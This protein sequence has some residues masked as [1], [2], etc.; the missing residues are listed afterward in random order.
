MGLLRIKFRNNPAKLRL[1]S[2]LQ[3]NANSIQGK[4][5][6]TL[7]FESAWE[8]GDAAYMLEDGTTLAQ[9]KTLRELCGTSQE[10]VTDEGAEETEASGQ[11]K[12]K[13]EHQGACARRKISRV[14]T[15][16]PALSLGGRGRTCDAAFGFEAR[17]TQRG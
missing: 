1:F 3:L 10:S 15:L 7:A 14:F 12:V 11:V 17:A 13:L 4:L 6:Q 8:Q 16:I 2:G 9:F 5:A